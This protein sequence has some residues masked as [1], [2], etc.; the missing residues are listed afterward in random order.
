MQ[1]RPITLHGQAL[2]YP[3]VCAPLVARSAEALIEECK[4][5]VAKKPDVIE[6]RVDFFE[7]IGDPR[8]V[9][10]T[11]ACLKTTA[12]GIPILFT[13]RNE[14]QGGEKIPLREQ[15]VVDLYRAVCANGATDLVDFEMD[16]EPTHVA[17]VRDYA[18]A[19]QI[20]LVL[21]FHD[22]NATPMVDDLVAKFERAQALGADVAKIA[23]MPKSN[24]DVFVLLAATSRASRQLLIPVISMAM[25]QVG[26]I[27]RTNGWLFGSA[28][29][30]AVVTGSSAPGQMPI[31]EV[32]SVIEAMKR[33]S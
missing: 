13:R 27:T 23:V 11:A 9:V 21:S 7:G 25:G 2:P 28:L 5:V 26:A 22:F 18:R 14:R 24:D 19:M 16:N 6:W 20:P 8:T 31:E 10:K 1:G 15:E 3:A 30:F 17:A 12:A 33:A 32:R 29:T 4:A